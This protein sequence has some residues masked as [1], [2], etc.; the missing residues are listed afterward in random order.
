MNG[1]NCL[2]RIVA[3]HIADEHQLI[4]WAG[5]AIQGQQHLASRHRRPLHDGNRG[6]QRSLG[7][8]EIVAASQQPAKA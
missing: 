1:G 6:G 2:L 7:G 5:V 4:C 8:V 3:G